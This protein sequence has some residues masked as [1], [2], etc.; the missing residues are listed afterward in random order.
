MPIILTED[1]DWDELNLVYDI[2]TQAKDINLTG[3]VE[4]HERGNAELVD[5]S[6]H[7][8][9]GYIVVPL[10]CGQELYDVVEITDALVGLTAAKKRALSLS[11]AYAPAKG[12]YV[13]KIGLGAIQT[14]LPPEQG[15]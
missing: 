13:L 1:W 3:T 6:M 10:N 14:P 5:A 9:D 2:L 8:Q 11:H 4:G 7:A 12:Q 15:G